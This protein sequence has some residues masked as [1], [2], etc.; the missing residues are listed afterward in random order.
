MKEN[1]SFCIPVKEM[2]KKMGIGLNTAYILANKKS[3]Y[4]AIRI[5]ANRIV[6]SVQLLQKWVE[7]QSFKQR[8]Y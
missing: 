4:P 1:E 2:A 7:E 3:F 5:S 6:I 8:S